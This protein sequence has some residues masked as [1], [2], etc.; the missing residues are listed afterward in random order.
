MIRF[1]LRCATI[2]A[3]QSLPYS[4]ECE[5]WNSIAHPSANVP[6]WQCILTV[7]HFSLMRT[8]KKNE[9][10][11]LICYRKNL[12]TK[13]VREL[14]LGRCLSGNAFRVYSP[15]DWLQTQRQIIFFSST[16][17]KWNLLFTNRII[18]RLGSSY[19]FIQTIFHL[20]IIFN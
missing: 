16:S 4:M 11:Y 1:S 12:W 19:R 20:I 13:R 5:A 9:N 17:L 8:G 18:N 3:Q 6:F 15:F 2:S 14:N 10:N 7:K